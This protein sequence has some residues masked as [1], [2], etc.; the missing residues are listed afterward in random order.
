MLLETKRSKLIAGIAL[1]VIG[2]AGLAL[3]AASGAGIPKDF[4]NGFFVGLTIVGCCVVLGRR[5]QAR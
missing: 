3:S 1:L 4:V 5:R 2:T